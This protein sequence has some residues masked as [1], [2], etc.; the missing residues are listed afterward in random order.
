MHTTTYTNVSYALAALHSVIHTA[1]CIALI[2]WSL[3]FKFYDICIRKLGFY[4]YYPCIC[5]YTPVTLM[6]ANAI[7]VPR[8]YISLL[9]MND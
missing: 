5:V 2:S 3:S 4:V 1:L 9:S 6:R 8:S 7:I